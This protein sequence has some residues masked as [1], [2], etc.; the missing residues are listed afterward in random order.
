M[1]RWDFANPTAPRPQREGEPDA[2]A[3]RKLPALF[4]DIGDQ[5]VPVIDWRRVGPALADPAHLPPHFHFA[6]D[7]PALTAL[8][9]APERTLL[10]A[11]Q[12]DWLGQQLAGSKNAGVTWQV[13]GNQ[14]VM[15]P[16]TAP[17]LT[18]TPAALAAQLE[19]V[20]PGVTRLLDFTRFPIPLDTDAWDGYPA[21]RARVLAKMRAAGG[22]A[23]VLAGDSHS[24]WAN[25]LND[26]EGR[27]AVEFGTTS[28]TSPSDAEYFKPAGIDFGAGLL[29]RNPHIKWNDQ[30]GRGF[31]KLTLTKQQALAEFFTV[32]TIRSKDFTTARDAAFTVAPDPGPSIGV[33]T[34]Q[35]GHT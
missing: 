2:A 27:V 25:E 22:N 16:V 5:F 15:A 11:A 8:L 10:G 30:L 32:S 24:A 34:P 18:R 20:R 29:A 26:A 31:L 9:N 4:E 7:V 28:I 13:L 21:A 17:D 23:I 19:R 6:P 35:S 12:E 33:I 14:V 3:M 1:Q